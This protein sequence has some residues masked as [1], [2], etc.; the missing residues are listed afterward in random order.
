MQN[1]ISNVKR[2]KQTI[3]AVK[4][5]GSPELFV[6]AMIE[7]HPNARQAIEYVEENGG[8]PKTAFYRLAKENRIDPEEIIKLLS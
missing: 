1:L 6:R 7:R 2:L 3:D 8:D 5:F 4:M